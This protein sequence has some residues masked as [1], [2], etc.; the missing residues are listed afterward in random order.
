M[1]LELKINK[2]IKNKFL[3]DSSPTGWGNQ[4]LICSEWIRIKQRM[5]RGESGVS[6]EKD[7]VFIAKEHKCNQEK[8]KD[9]L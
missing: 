1:D 4:D 5:Q 3:S 8:D 9:S 7:I 2:R 6:K